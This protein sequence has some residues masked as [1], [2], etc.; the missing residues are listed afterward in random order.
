MSDTRG[1]TGLILS[2]KSRLFWN[3]FSFVLISI[4]L[5]AVLIL[6]VF[7][8]IEETMYTTFEVVYEKYE[9][10]TLYTNSGVYEI[11][12]SE[13]QKENIEQVFQN[14]VNIGDVLEISI[15][16]ITDKVMSLKK[17]STTIIEIS[18]S[19][20]VGEIMLLCVVCS[21]PVILAIF[22]LLG[23]NLKNPKGVFYK[24]QRELIY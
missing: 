22:I 8:K 2:I 17:G 7:P 10:N 16:D 9:N 21:F 3:I 4:A 14:Q 12:R 24:I 6:V 13:K 19:T 5:Y 20:T 15:G 11:K 18:P 23:V 1:L